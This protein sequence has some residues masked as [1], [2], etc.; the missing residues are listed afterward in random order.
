MASSEDPHE[1]ERELEAAVAM[2]VVEVCLAAEREAAL[3]QGLLLAV[4]SR[5]TGCRDVVGADGHRRGAF[6]IDDR[7]DADWL[8]GIGAAEPGAMP[9]LG[10]AAR[11]A[12]GVIAANMAFGR[13]SGV[14]GDDLLRFALSAYAAGTVA[15]LEGYGLGDPDASTPGGD[16]GRDVLARLAAVERWL[17]RR[18]RGTR[19]PTLLPGS[20]GDAVVELK[21]LLRAWY[22]ARAEVPPRRMR[23]PV[24]G[25]GAVEAVKE[26][27][28]AHQLPADGVVGPETWR[29]LEAAQGSSASNPAA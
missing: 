16:Y 29:L 20:R 17:G 7:R 1:L 8:V 23:G 21:K 14:R 15:A 11:Y 27:Q 18:G 24:Y 13:A 9:P 3:P 6:G 4:S 5:E 2:G 10:A 12:A 26:F 25:T 22:A 19:H 28:Q